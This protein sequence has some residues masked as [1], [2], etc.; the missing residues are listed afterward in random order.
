MPPFMRENASR[1]GH[2]PAEPER[3]T[4][5]GPSGQPVLTC[6]HRLIIDAETGIPITF[7][8]SD[9]GQSPPGVV[10]DYQ[11]SRVTTAD[12]ANG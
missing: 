8:G 5:I 10:V 7:I 4:E 1:I 12:I 3:A 2:I 11:V 6:P 9:P